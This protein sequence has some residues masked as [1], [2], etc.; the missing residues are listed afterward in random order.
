MSDN[1]LMVGD[2]RVL[3]K[4]MPYRFATDVPLIVRWDGHVA[5]GRRRPRLASTVDV[6][7]TIVRPPERRWRPADSTCSTRASGPSALEGRRWQRLD[8]SI[9]HPAYCGLRSAS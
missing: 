1:G 6:A 5:G 4:N 8:G 9:P 7:T 2:H 3:G